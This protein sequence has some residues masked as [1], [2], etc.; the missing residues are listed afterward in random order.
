MIVSRILVFFLQ[1][2]LWRTDDGWLVSLRPANLFN[3]GSE[4]CSR[5]VC[6]VSGYQIIHLVNRSDS[7]MKSI[8]LCLGWQRNVNDQFRRQRFNL[9]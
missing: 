5:N 1:H 9:V 3:F 8:R 2:F 6:A 4:S 7:N